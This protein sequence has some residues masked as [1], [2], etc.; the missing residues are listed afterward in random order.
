M[1]MI[2]LENW[3]LKSKLKSN[4]KSKEKVSCESFQEQIIELQKMQLKAFEESEKRQQQFFEQMVEAQCKYDAAEK[5]KDRQFFMELA[6]VL[7]K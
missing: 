4:V 3:K 1:K 6:K 5:E 2:T 7:S